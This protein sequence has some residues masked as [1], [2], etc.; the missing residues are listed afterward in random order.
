MDRNS[1]NELQFIYVA[2]GL[3]LENQTKEKMNDDM[4]RDVYKEG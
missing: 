2:W 4:E 3:G 1:Q